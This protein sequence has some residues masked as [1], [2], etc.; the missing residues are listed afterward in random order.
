MKAAVVHGFDRPLEIEDVPIP[1]PGPSRCSS[2]SRPAASA[3]PTSTPPAASGRSSRRRRSSPATRASGSSSAL[4]PGNTPRHRGRACA[5]RCPG[6]ATP[7]ATAATATPAARR[8]A[9]RQQN[10]GYA[11]N[12]GFAEY[13]VGYARH[14]VPRPGRDRPARRRAADLRRRHDLQGGQGLRRGVRRASSPSSASAASA[15]WRSSTRAITGAAVVAV[16]INE[17]RLRVAARARRRARRARRRGGPGRGDPARSAAP[18][19]RS[20]PPSTRSPSSRRSAR[21]PAA[22]RSS[23]SGCRPTTT[24]RVPIFETVLG[25]LTDHG[26]DRRHPPRPRGGLR[27]APPRA[28]ARARRAECRLDDVNEAIEQVLD[29]S[30]PA[31]RIVF[32]MTPVATAPAVSGA[33][34]A[35]A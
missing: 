14:V 31:P 21:W 6:S 34:T 27:A 25:G 4:G 10:T 19:R 7:A 5:S 3:T 18:T 35:G 24:M 20:R 17:E 12:G 15:T 13:A 33:A 8:S 16:D 9:C 29:G 23:A 32:D 30:A 11:I 28:D 2:A 1:E 26:L 22:A